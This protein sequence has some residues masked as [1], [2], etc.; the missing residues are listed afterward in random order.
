[1]L[2]AGS[3]DG[4]GTMDWDRIA[5]V[6]EVIGAIA[7]V[8]SLVYVALQIRQNSSALNRSNKY[9]QATSVHESNSL[10]IQVFSTDTGKCLS[11]G[12]YIG[13]QK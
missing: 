7:V 9:A 13:M 1:M 11:R 12:L 3:T 5:A 6:S 2:F 10:F 4:E 8:V